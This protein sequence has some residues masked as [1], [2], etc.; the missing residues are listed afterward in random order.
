MTASKVAGQRPNVPLT[1]ARPAEEVKGPPKEDAPAPAAAPA[2]EAWASTTFEPSRGL[3]HTDGRLSANAPY[4]K[5]PKD[6]QGK[7]TKT[8]WD[9]LPEG[10]RGNLVASYQNFKRLGVW[11][12]ITK[13][14]GEKEK[15]E[16]PVK[17]PGGVE[18]Q[19]AGNS[20]D[21]QY[22]IKDRKGFTNK[23]TIINP[24]F[25]IDGG[26]MGAMHGGQLSM[27]QSGEPTSFHIA[28]GPGD[29]MDA[30]IDKVNPVNTP[31]NG[32]T[33][34]DLQRGLKHWTTEVLPELIRDVLGVPGIIIKPEL[35]PG[36]K[37]DAGHDWTP[38]GRGE[39]TD[40]RVTVNLELHF[41]GKKTPEKKIHR[42]RIEGAQR[43]GSPSVPDSAMKEIT[44]RV[45]ESASTL[46]LP[47][48]PGRKDAKPVAQE[49]AANLAAKMQEAV[50]KGATQIS[51][52]LVQYAG[53][54]GQQTAVVGDLRRISEI[55][56]SEMQNAGVDVSKISLL[57][58]TFGTRA[59]RASIVILK[60][61]TRAPAPE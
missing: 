29:R 14:V 60:P 58:I 30:H 45:E 21:I 47:A 9:K 56:R 34:L 8:V 11:D 2:A 3:Q 6:L 41:G 48:P 57:N 43:E 27:R 59:E 39:P 26:I 24:K 37:G 36:G 35:T 23:L 7:M 5:L 4:E 51:I 31:K 25:G 61:G 52:D 42:E 17:F 28:L 18:A 40:V 20:G 10:Q 33:Q 13:V 38:N 46:A 54:K 50:E 22:E 15:L 44:R 49:L 55:V 19:V 12:H 32:M 53:L 1:N 16:A